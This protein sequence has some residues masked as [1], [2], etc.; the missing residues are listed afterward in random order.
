M[1]KAQTSFVMRVSNDEMEGVERE[2]EVE[3]VHDRSLV[4][5]SRFVCDELYLRYESILLK[6][7]FI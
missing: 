5:G 7:N 4:P 3:E 6:M 2:G 1:K